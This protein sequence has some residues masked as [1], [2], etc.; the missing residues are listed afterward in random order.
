MYRQATDFCLLILNVV[1]LLNSFT[2]FNSYFVESLGFSLYKIMSS[3]TRDNFTSF[4][5]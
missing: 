2:S 3:V 5:I 4:L 1:T